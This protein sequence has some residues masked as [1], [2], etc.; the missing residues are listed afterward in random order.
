MNTLLLLLVL[1][2]APWRPNYWPRVLGLQ[3]LHHYELPCGALAW[4]Q[5]SDE[6]IHLCHPYQGQLQWGPIALHESQHAMAT[7]YLS[8][9]DWEGFGHQAIKALNSTRYSDE[10]RWRADASL[11]LGGHE[12]HADLPLITAG[13]IPSS[14]AMWYPWFW[15]D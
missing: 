7:L 6:T 4:W 2:L 11:S 15:L 8:E 3:I 5:A 9:P 10:Q 14:L 12:L 1:S 13:R